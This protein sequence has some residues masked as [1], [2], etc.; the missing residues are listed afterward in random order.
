MLNAFD[1]EHLQKEQPNKLY[2][3]E[4]DI[5]KLTEENKKLKAEIYN[6]KQSISRIEEQMVDRTDFTKILKEIVK[7][8]RQI[9]IDLGKQNLTI[10]QKFNAMLQSSS[11][12]IVS[13]MINELR[14]NPQLREE[15]G[16]IMIMQLRLRPQLRFQMKQLINGI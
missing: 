1:D 2:S 13:I 5:F 4:L 16:S 15:I 6:M 11:P 8:S 9:I 14:R 7:Q 10:P 3:T 12:Q